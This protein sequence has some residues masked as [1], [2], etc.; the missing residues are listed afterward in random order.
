MFCL[1]TSFEMYRLMS[2]V[3]SYQSFRCGWIW[4]LKGI[5]GC[6]CLSSLSSVS[7]WWCQEVRPLRGA[8]LPGTSSRSQGTLL[9]V[10]SLTLPRNN[11]GELHCVSTLSKLKTCPHCRAMILSKGRLTMNLGRISRHTTQG[12]CLWV[13]LSFLPAMNHL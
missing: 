11:P 4:G 7:P 3:S 12:S 5:K 9:W 8:A 10:S 13:I 1:C 2:M 6:R